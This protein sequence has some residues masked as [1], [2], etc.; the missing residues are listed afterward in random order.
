[1]QVHAKA[2]PSKQSL[3]GR[4]LRRQQSSD[5]LDSTINSSNAVSEHTQPQVTNLHIYISYQ[6]VAS[7]NA[8]CADVNEFELLRLM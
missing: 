3:F 5:T 4:M 7:L 2:K 6:P 1:V 8:R